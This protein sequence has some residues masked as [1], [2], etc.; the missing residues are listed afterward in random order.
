[1]TNAKFILNWNI[2]EEQVKSLFDLGLSVSYSYKTNHEVGDVLQDLNLGTYFS[3]HSKDEIKMIKDKSKIIFFIQAESFE[4]LEGIIHQGILN[5]VVDNEIDFNNILSVAK[6]LNVKINLSIRMKFQENRIGTG[7]YFVYGLPSKR[8][9]ELI[10]REKENKFIDK[11]GIHIHRKSQNT[12]EW[13]IISELN[14]SIFSEVFDRL[15]FI[16]LGGGLPVKYK[17]YSSD[18]LNYIFK[19]LKETIEWLKERKVEIFIEPGRYI[20]A[21]SIKLETEIIQIQDKNI[22]LNTTIYNCAL[23]TILTGT[24]MIIE[25]ELNDNE[26]GDYYLIKGNSPTRDDIFRYNVKLKNPKVGDKIVFLNAG[27]YNYTTDFF[28]YTKLKTVIN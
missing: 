12:S 5:F 22:I 7:K 18:I 25:G 13:E 16:N 15:D 6:S 14:D 28:G 9:N 27:A 2:V 8:V 20:A 24:K 21:P 23:D 19:K 3:I 1:M 11:F 17:S 26:E 4:E 10:I